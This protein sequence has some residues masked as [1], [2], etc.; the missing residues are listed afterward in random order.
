M[1]T[2]FL[3]QIVCG[4]LTSTISRGKILGMTMMEVTGSNIEGRCQTGNGDN[5]FS[6]SGS[7]DTRRPLPRRATVTKGEWFDKRRGVVGSNG[8][9]LLSLLGVAP[10]AQVQRTTRKEMDNRHRKNLTPR[11]CE[12]LR[13][14]TIAGR[15]QPPTK[16]VTDYVLRYSLSTKY[17][18]TKHC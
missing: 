8:Q 7:Y 14:E 4:R 10:R 2:L 16:T 6:G 18:T 15:G 1:K 13:V 3:Q 17:R 12:S 5:S 9:R 11:D